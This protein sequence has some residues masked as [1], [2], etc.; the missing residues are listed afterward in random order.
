MATLLAVWA[1][2]VTLTHAGALWRDEVGGVQFAT[3]LPLGEMCRKLAYD[4]FPLF[5]PALVRVWSTLGLGGSDLGLRILGFLIGLGLL[6]GIWLNARLMRFGL[7]FISLGL[8]ATNV[9]LVFWGD[10]LRAYGCGCTFILLTLGLLWRLAQAPG[11]TSFLLAALAATL[12]VQTLYQNAFLV[13]AACGAGGVVCARRRQWRTAALVLGV[14]LVAAISL[15]PYVPL[16]IEAQAWYKLA[17]IGFDAERVWSNLLL[18][19]GAPLHWLV[20]VWGGLL[21]LVFAVGWAS[22]QERARPARVGSEDLPLF[23]VSAL[24]AGTALFFV[25]LR[26][27]ELV[28]APW[29]FLPLMVFAAA[30]MDAALADWCRQFRPW[31]LAFVAVMVCLPFPAT[32][33]LAK[34]RQTNIDLIADEL[35]REAKPGDLIL[36][37]PFF[38]GI[39]FDRYFK[40]PVAWTT[41]PPIDDHRFYRMDQVRNG[42]CSKPLLRSVLA[43]MAHALASGH[44]LWMVG[45]WPPP[46]PGET[47]PPD[48][49]DPPQ[50][51]QPF[52]F[53]ESSQCTYAWERQAVHLIATRAAHAGVIPVQPATPVSEAE[54]VRLIRASGWRGE[55]EATPAPP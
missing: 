35:Q 31:V 38:L 48:L 12:S 25:F 3:L 11:R 7:P 28:T 27:S 33:K 32:L 23:A 6:G 14:G 41:L 50:P 39:T 55:P 21:P 36:V 45:N 40:G 53:A 30:T 10:S 20:W 34:Y 44:T 26:A 42:L 13:L 17:K 43:R 52:G 54:K 29:Y 16:I 4:S 9:T 51:G 47:V 22:L 5:F 15:V 8:L 46:Q 19:L 24:V 2:V 49:P 1:H 37:S 18:A